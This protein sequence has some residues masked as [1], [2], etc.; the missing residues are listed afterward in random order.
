MAEVRSVFLITNLSKKKA[1]ELR[2]DILDF[3]QERKIRVFEH[4]FTG[5][6]EAVTPHQADLV[7]VLGGDGTVLYSARLC[8]GLGMPILAV[9]LGTFGFLAEVNPTEWKWA[10]EMYEQDQMGL[11]RRVMLNTVLKRRGKEIFNA[12]CLNDCVITSTGMAKL[13]NLKVDISNQE[14]IDYRANG[15]ILSTSTGSTGYSLAAGGPILHP[16]LTAM[17]VNPINPFTLSNRP[18]VIPADEEV[19]VNIVKNQR[20][21]LVMTLDGQIVVELLPGDKVVTKR[22]SCSADLLSFSTMNFYEVVRK[23]LNWK[24]RPYD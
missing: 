19:T 6:P 11:S 14:V 22:H 24:G 9:N 2:S 17:I 10:F 18:L 5:E 23:K 16:E 7:I 15:V 1:D 3:L 13:V 4:T 21:D 12:C 20:T 8:A